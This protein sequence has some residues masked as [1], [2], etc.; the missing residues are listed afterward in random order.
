MSNR[1]NSIDLDAYRQMGDPEADKLVGDTLGQG[2][3]GRI[4]YNTLVALSNKLLEEPGLIFVEDSKVAQG[5]KAYADSPLESDQELAA[6]FKPEPA[7]AWVDEAKL[8]LASKL[9]Q[10]NTVAAL[11]VLYAASLPFCYLIEKGIPALYKTGKLLP[12]YLTQR[13]Y[14]TGL[15]VDSV[16]DKDGIALIEDKI[17]DFD[18]L[19]LD[20]LKALGGSWKRSGN[21]IV[22]EGGDG[23]PP[24]A[25]LVEQVEKNIRAKLEQPVRYLSGRGYLTA[26]KVRFLHASMRYMLLQPP[27]AASKEEG[28]RPLT[29]FFAESTWDSQ[30]LGVPVNQ[31]DQAYTLLTF[32]LAIP[33]GL[34]KWG[35]KLSLEEKEAF[36]HLW[37][38]IGYLMGI[39]EELLTDNWEEAE[40]L[41]ALIQ[42]R[43]CGGSPD[44]IALTSALIG[45]LE[46]YLPK[47]PGSELNCLPIELIISQIGEDYASQLIDPRLI[48]KSRNFWRKP[49][50]AALGLGSRLY[51]ALRSQWLKRLPVLGEFTTELVHKVSEEVIL[52]WRDAYRREPFFVPKDAEHW[53]RLIGATPE[54]L[55]TLQ[56]WRQ[57]VL[58][59]AGFGLGLLG[60]AI[61]GLAA[62]LPLWLL[63]GQ[64]GLLI[65]LGVTA[66]SWGAFARIANKKLAKLLAARPQPEAG[67]VRPASR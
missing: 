64:T 56:D 12:P 35:V 36:L 5:L 4:K 15:M 30:A 45:M 3:A 2:D 29:D 47:L 41:F 27:V 61:F 9:W 59:T 31:E 46:E 6:Y 13:I 39:R 8:G 48:K 11:G 66:L 58:Y 52:S 37:K 23:L 16:L 19:V 32:G 55:A 33:R 43:Q 60:V 67:V 28:P 44:G 49:L 57:K 17:Y 63:E 1:W 14:E 42:K 10:E 62:A 22:R 25:E 40:E 38:L 65:A 50:Y 26:K 18:G 24:A 51:F 7:P 54:Y 34:E 21:Q 53:Q 20:E